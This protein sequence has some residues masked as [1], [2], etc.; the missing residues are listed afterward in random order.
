MPEEGELEV[1]VRFRPGLNLSPGRHVHQFRSKS[2][3]FGNRAEILV[4]GPAIY[5]I[6]PEDIS[7]D[8][9]PLCY[10]ERSILYAR[11]II[12]HTC[13]DV[14]LYHTVNHLPYFSC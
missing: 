7:S 2:S 4:L 5:Q 10:R 14:Y 3:Y 13:I 6:S 12:Y 11:I 1:P 9:F 8:I